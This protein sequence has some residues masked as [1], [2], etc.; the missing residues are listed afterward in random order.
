[1]GRHCA[2]DGC[3]TPV[4]G[5]RK[6]CCDRCKG[7]VAMER[8]RAQLRDRSRVCGRPGCRRYVPLNRAGSE[9]C[10]ERCQEI[11]EGCLAK[12]EEPKT[13]QREGCGRPIPAGRRKF[14]CTK[15]SKRAT[16]ARA[17]QER[18][19]GGSETTFD[20]AETARYRAKFMR[21]AWRRCLIC[22]AKF[23][24]DGP[25]NRVCR[26]DRCQAKLAA[27]VVEYPTGAGE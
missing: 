1:M 12:G 15:C 20:E 27:L 25:W 3:K 4:S 2:R 23:W 8:H 13:C 19:E 5:K 16:A 21:P 9:F 14:C 18:F 11:A 10:S 22:R 26:D 24:S 7:A 17:S 6:Y